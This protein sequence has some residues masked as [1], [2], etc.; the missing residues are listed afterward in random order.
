MN[1]DATEVIDVEGV[2][3]TVS[4]DTGLLA[5]LVE[6]FDLEIPG[7]RSRLA[8]ALRAEDN[9]AI[10]SAAHRLKGS[11]ATLGACCISTAEQLELAAQRGG[12]DE[13]RD[14]ARRLEGE[15]D[16]VVPALRALIQGGAL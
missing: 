6:L 15:L 14:L 5:E 3:R 9:K 1:M 2:R 10:A 16:E 11:L 12:G 8:D 13:V 7:L 4:G